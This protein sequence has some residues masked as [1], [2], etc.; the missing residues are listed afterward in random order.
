MVGTLELLKIVP[1]RVRPSLSVSSTSTICESTQGSKRKRSDDSKLSHND[2][3]ESPTQEVQTGISTGQQGPTITNPNGL[4]S[5]RIRLK[6]KSRRGESVTDN[7]GTVVPATD[8]EPVHDVEPNIAPVIEVEDDELEIIEVRPAPVTQ[9]TQSSVRSVPVSQV[10]SER[11]RERRKKLL[12]MRLA[13]TK[14]ERTEM[15]LEREL[16][17]LED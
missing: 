6:L 10:T 5:P 9:T 3:E 11:D 4:P 2:H 1:K 13:E 14:L 12:K 15:K 16:F 8:H 17:E 7:A